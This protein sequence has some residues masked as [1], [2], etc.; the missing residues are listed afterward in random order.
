ADRLGIIIRLNAAE[1]YANRL[2]AVELVND[3]AD[4]EAAPLEP[5]PPVP[6]GDSPVSSGSTAARATGMR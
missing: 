4:C 5:G 3:L 2:N 1:R 6:S